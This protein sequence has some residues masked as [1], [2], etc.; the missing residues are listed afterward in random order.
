[1]A[2]IPKKPAWLKV[3]LP[4]L[5]KF[6]EVRKTLREL[7]LHTVCEE[8]LCPNIGTCW[9]QGHVTFMILG[10][11]CTR[12]CKFCAT[13]TGRPAP[14]EPDEPQRVAEAVKRLNLKYV[15]ITSVTRDDLPDGGASYF[16]ETTRL[17][18]ELGVPVEVLVPDFGAREELIVQVLEAEPT[19]FAHNVEVVR[20]LTPL[21]RDRRAGYDKSL[22]VLE[23]A[24]RRGKSVVKSGL[25]VGLGETFDEVIETLK[26]LR[27]VGVEAVSI[28]QYLQPTRRHYPVHR[29]VPPEEFEEY[30]KAAKEMGFKWVKS[31]PLV[32]TSYE[33]AEI[34]E[35]IGKS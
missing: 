19:V 9:A 14:P 7:R 12:R 21:V 5:G 2:G 4:G 32:R 35:V 11:V 33:A 23:I 27:D 30:A 17:V 20:R 24:S 22:K 29:Y 10:D 13:K 26:D 1:M 15:I 34:L 16:A 6:P 18:R 3:P 25:M 31:G 28:G 8:S